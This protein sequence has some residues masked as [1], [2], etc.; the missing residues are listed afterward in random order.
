MQVF[1]KFFRG[2]CP[3]TPQE[4]FLG[5]WFL[6]C[7]KLTLPEKTTLEKVTKVGALFLKKI[8]NTPLT[9]KIFKR[10]IY[11]RFRVYTSLYLV[12]IQLSSKLHPL[13]KIF[14]IRSCIQ[15]MVKCDVILNPSHC[16]ILA[17]LVGFWPI[18]IV[19]MDRVN[20]F[21]RTLVLFVY[22]DKIHQIFQK[23]K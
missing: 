22:R 5:F 11:A 1:S 23:Q 13:H 14:W 6:N 3:R 4:S 16:K 7:L 15:R 12:N 17:T 9:S 20:E 18:N 19:H 2:A 21:R 10:L 8:L